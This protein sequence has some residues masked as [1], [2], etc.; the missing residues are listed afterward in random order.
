MK[1]NVY[2]NVCLMLKCDQNTC[3]YNYDNNAFNGV[4]DDYSVEIKYKQI[5]KILN[6]RIDCHKQDIFC[7]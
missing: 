3:R 6:K 1:G 5:S 2:A 7:C 4:V